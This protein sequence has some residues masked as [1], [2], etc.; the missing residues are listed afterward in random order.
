MYTQKPGHEKSLFLP[1]KYFQ[2]SSEEMVCSLRVK[3]QSLHVI[4]D[5]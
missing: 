1:T 5:I 4:S 3:K 2:K